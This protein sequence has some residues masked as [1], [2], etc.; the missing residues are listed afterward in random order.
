MGFVISQLGWELTSVE[1]NYNGI[2]SIHGGGGGGGR[3][4]QEVEANQRGRKGK[5]ERNRGG[6]DSGLSWIKL[7][8]VPCSLTDCVSTQMAHERAG[9]LVLLTK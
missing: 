4:M 6:L 2:I 7:L 3:E 9:Q 8:T 5:K 1:Q